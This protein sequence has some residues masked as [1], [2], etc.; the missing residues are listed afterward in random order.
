[1]KTQVN[2][3]KEKGL[4]RQP[5]YVHSISGNF[6][7][8]LFSQ[9]GRMRETFLLIQMEFGFLESKERA[10]AF[11]SAL[12]GCPTPVLFLPESI[13][14]N[15]KSIGSIIVPLSGEHRLS[16]SL[17]LAIQLADRVNIPVDT[18][19]VTLPGEACSCGGD[20]E[21]SCDEFQHEYY[22]KIEQWVAEGCPFAS[23]RERFRVRD[24]YSCYGD[25]SERICSVVKKTSKRLLILEW[26]GF[27]S[28]GRA[29]ILKAILKSESCPIFLVR[30]AVSAPLRLKVGTEF[31]SLNRIG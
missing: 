23:S 31:A 25:V 13:S 11:K 3:L 28:Q 7:S 4:L 12:E 27:F 6:I 2:K 14:L 22:G 16:E 29:R 17:T 24:F 26:K 18:M 21:K 8:G 15:R 19:H 5:F 30:A 9:I 20:L 1:L 10:E